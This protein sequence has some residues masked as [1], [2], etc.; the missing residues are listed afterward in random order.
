LVGLDRR[1][2]EE[3]GRRGATDE[4]EP[5]LVGGE[6]DHVVGDGEA[7]VGDVRERRHDAAP[8]GERGLAAG[9]LVADG[10]GAVSADPHRDR[11]AGRVPDE[12]RVDEVGGGAGLAREVH[13]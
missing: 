8:H 12:P 11:V 3:L 5:S 6:Q 1:D 4:A 2:G 7:L 9:L 10:R 13:P